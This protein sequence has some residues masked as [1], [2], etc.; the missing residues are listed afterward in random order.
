M[1]RKSRHVRVVIQRNRGNGWPSSN[2]ATGSIFA[3]MFVDG[4]LA[5]DTHQSK[6]MWPM[7]LLY[8]GLQGIGL[9]YNGQGEK[10]RWLWGKTASR[11]IQK[12]SRRS[13]VSGLPTTR[14]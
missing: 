2:F 7:S 6:G 13:P 5:G 9:L 10:E 11:A 3:W 1:K 4:E 14:R 12:L 8:F